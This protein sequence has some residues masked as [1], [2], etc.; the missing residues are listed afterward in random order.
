M[1][2]VYTDSPSEAASFIREGGVVAF[3]T[4]TVFG[5]GADAT[6]ESAVEKIYR[7]KGRPSDN[8][9]I[10][11]VHSLEQVQ[12]VG[13][14]A[15][16]SGLFEGWRRLTARRRIGKEMELEPHSGCR[17]DKTGHMK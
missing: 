10:V 13:V 4:E 11:H 2:T 12:E 9:L 14:E 7:A 15:W 6:D 8:P 16:K 1:K 17:G 5:L 3:A